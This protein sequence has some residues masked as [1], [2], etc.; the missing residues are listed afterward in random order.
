MFTE[1]ELQTFG[2]TAEKITRI[3][4]KQRGGANSRKGSKF[5]LHF[6]VYQL[7]AHFQEWFQNNTPIELAEQ[8]SCFVDD[9]WTQHSDKEAFFQLKNVQNPSW[10]KEIVEDFKDQQ[11]LNQK[12]GKSATLYLVCNSCKNM[13]QME[14]TMP[15]GLQADVKVM[16]MPAAQ[17]WQELYQRSPE[18]Q[19]FLNQ[20]CARQ[21]PEY[22]D[23]EVILKCLAAEWEDHP[24][25]TV[26]YHAFIHAFYEKHPCA[27]LKRKVTLPNHWQQACTILDNIPYLAYNADNGYFEWNVDNLDQGFFPSPVGTT[28]F[29]RFLQRIIERQPQTFDD[30]EVLL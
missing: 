3:Q 22:T 29:E 26:N 25:G 23:F 4:N 5:E 7:L 8:V 16:Q 10:T 14:R 19:Q 2:F 13:H 15:D 1:I 27:L 21:Q 6:A 24:V 11:K 30:L 20:A 9:F 18:L 17:L 28:G 12:S